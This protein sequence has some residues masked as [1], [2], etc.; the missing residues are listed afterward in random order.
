MLYASMSSGREDR[1][2][3][4]L[5]RRHDAIPGVGQH[6][7]LMAPRMRKLG[8]AVAQDDQRSVAGLAYL[9]LNV[10]ERDERRCH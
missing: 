6:R 3:P 8:E 9:K 4:A 2:Y 1:P 10:A 5:V 7:N